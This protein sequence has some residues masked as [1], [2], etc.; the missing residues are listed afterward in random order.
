M[1]IGVGEKF[2]AVVLNDVSSN[3]SG[4]IP[5]S[6]GLSAHSRI[7]VALTDDWVEA[8]GKLHADDLQDANLTLLA[9]AASTNPGQLDYENDA[10]TKTA[11]ILFHALLLVGVPHYR[12]GT[13][14]SGAN[15]TGQPRVRSVSTMSTY[16]RLS[17][18]PQGPLTITNA[19]LSRA[20]K[21]EQTMATVYSSAVS[22]DPLK[23]GLVVFAKAMQE[24]SGEGRL[25]QLV[26]SLDA[27]VRGD[28][29]RG[30]RQFVDR[31]QTFSRASA[32]A[33]Q[34]LQDIYE[35]RSK[36]AHARSMNELFDQL[37]TQDKEKRALHRVRQA[38]ALARHSFGEI[39][40]SP[41]LTS[42]FSSVSST[43][44][45]WKN[46]HHLRNQAWSN[47]LDLLAIP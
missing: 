2:A 31:C 32:G 10:L 9:V 47:R 16:F 25:L 38:E 18:D 27:L 26:R 40:T 44:Q 34:T 15:E 42:T 37:S 41:S 8:V 46:P 29:G 43:E 36:A 12:R 14:I 20:G 13:I 23:N 7:P 5:L 33:D 11:M 22:G 3:V 28:I 19:S 6:G 45:F 39:L 4:P 1:I 21:I 30:K 24:Q 35:L 17:H